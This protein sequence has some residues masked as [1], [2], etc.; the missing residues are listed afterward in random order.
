M[1]IEEYEFGTLTIAD[2]FIIGEMK[3][4]IEVSFEIVLSIIA[5]AKQHF[6]ENKWGY[7][8]NRIHSFSTDPTVYRKS[9]EFDNTLVAFA[10]VV[11]RHISKTLTYIEN[12]YIDNCFKYSHFDNLDDAINWMVPILSE[13]KS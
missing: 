9:H 4:G 11:Y 7:I 10:A 8:S 12:E 13:E 1:K 5:V 2:G 3:E 6:G